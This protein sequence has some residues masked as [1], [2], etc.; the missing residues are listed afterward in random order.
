MKWTTTE[1]CVFGHKKFTYLLRKRISHEQFQF[2]LSDVGMRAREKYIKKQEDH[3][4]RKDVIAELLKF[5]ETGYGGEWRI[6]IE[7]QLFHWLA[8]D[9]D[10]YFIEMKQTS[11]G[12]L[13]DIRDAGMISAKKHLGR[14][15]VVCPCGC[16][17]SKNSLSRHR[18]T[19]GH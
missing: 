14:E 4:K 19:F 12:F 7:F 15:R 13:K 16:V 17:S 10:A 8:W 18:K 9:F 2:E 1:D 6:P 3:F 11:A 5:H